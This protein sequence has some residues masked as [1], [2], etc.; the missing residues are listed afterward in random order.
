MSYDLLIKVCLRSKICWVRCTLALWVYSGPMVENLLTRCT[1]TQRCTVALGCTVALQRCTVA[2]VWRICGRT[3]ILL[4]LMCVQS[5][6]LW[7][8]DLATVDVLVS[9]QNDANVTGWIFFSNCFQW[10]KLPCKFASLSYG[11]L[12]FFSINVSQGSVA[13]CLRCGGIL[14]TA[15]S[16]IYC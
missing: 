9:E 12:R 13:T 5:L 8:F 15:L 10:L 16:E 6:I 4:I 3:L 2:P 14:V 11:L 7:V 1:L